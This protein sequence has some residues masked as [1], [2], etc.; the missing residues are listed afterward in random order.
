MNRAPGWCDTCQ[1]RTLPWCHHGPSA[2]PG[3]CAAF[4][5]VPLVSD[6]SEGEVPHASPCLKRAGHPGLHLA[7][8]EFGEPEEDR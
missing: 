4:V 8:V 5:L 1:A 7:Q 3:P 6:D 2:P